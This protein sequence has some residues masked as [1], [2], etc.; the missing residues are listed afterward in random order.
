MT[1]QTVLNPLQANLASAKEKLRRFGGARNRLTD[2]QPRE[3]VIT[4]DEAIA[5]LMKLDSLSQH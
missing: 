1:M 3:V 5:I 2:R 4:D